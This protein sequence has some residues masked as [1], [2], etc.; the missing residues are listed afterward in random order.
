MKRNP[1]VPEDVA[2]YNVYPA[3]V[4]GNFYISGASKIKSSKELGIDFS[5]A[6]QRHIIENERKLAPGLK[7]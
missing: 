1:A 6:D 7:P 5:L 2:E 4:H 3:D